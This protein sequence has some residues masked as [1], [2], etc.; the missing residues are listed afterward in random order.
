MLV[1]TFAEQV[2]G[3]GDLSADE[4]HLII[5]TPHRAF[6]E[7][8]GKWKTRGIEA[9]CFP[10]C[11]VVEGVD[12]SVVGGM[13]IDG[14]EAWLIKFKGFGPSLSDGLGVTISVG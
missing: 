14:S 12:E 7:F 8:D 13:Q 10:Y 3:I 9:L 6:G 2:I 4:S 1:H 11:V 5:I